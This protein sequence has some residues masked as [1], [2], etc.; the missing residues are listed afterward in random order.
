MAKRSSRTKGI[1]SLIL[2]SFIFAFYAVVARYLSAGFTIAQQFYIRMFLAFLL[3]FFSF[4]SYSILKKLKTIPTKDWLIIIFRTISYYLIGT[5]LYVLAVLNTK[6]GNVAVIGSLPLVAVFGFLLGEKF[7]WK[8]LLF[9][10]LAFLGTAIMG[11]TNYKDLLAW[12]K[13]DLLALISVIFFS[14][15]YVARKW[16]SNALTNREITT[17]IFF[18]A[19]VLFL[20][21]SFFLKEG[22]PTNIIDI[23]FLFFFLLGAILNVAGMFLTNYGFEHVDNVLASNILTLE[24]VF[25]ILLGLVFYREVPNLKEIIGSI[26]I[27]SSVISLN[28]AESK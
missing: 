23:N 10:L 27:I 12:N 26:L 22:L 17:L 9:V 11:I 19:T 16:Q 14:L 7:T 24:A 21:S 4:R 13:G 1:L 5:V 6:I 25:G 3:A 28:N 20:I 15:S 18:F 8:K 2:L